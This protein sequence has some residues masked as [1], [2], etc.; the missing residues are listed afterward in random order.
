[1]PQR[2]GSGV[3]EIDAVATRVPG[4]HKP[5]QPSAGAAAGVASALASFGGGGSDFVEQKS[6]ET[7]HGAFVEPRGSPG[8]RD[9][10]SAVIM[11]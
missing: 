9:A 11:T 8:W 2:D 6:V 1:M 5:G 10:T 4:I 7:S 3:V